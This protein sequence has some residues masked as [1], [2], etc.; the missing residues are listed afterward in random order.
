MCVCMKENDGTGEQFGERDEVEVW[1]SIR[2]V[3]SR[4]YLDE[5][6]RVGLPY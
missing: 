4:E 5:R 6:V 3:Y 1:I 2:Y